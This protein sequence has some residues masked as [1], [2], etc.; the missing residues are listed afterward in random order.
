MNRRPNFVFYENEDCTFYSGYCIKFNGDSEWLLEQLN[1]ERMQ[2]FIEVSSRDFRGG[3]KA[4]NKKV[5]EN[6]IVEMPPL[7]TT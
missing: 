4:Y 6:F 2:R 7:V 5:V 3:W 1:S